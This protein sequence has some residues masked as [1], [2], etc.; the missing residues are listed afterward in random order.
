MEVV[1][2]L[3]VLVDCKIWIEERIH[4]KPNCK[5]GLKDG[6]LVPHLYL[7]QKLRS[8]NVCSCSVKKYT[9]TVSSHSKKKVMSDLF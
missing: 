9:V 3:K 6:S 8:E 5:G 7:D 1:H 4:N 2:V